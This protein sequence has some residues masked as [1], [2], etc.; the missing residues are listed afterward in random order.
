MNSKKLTE[1]FSAIARIWKDLTRCKNRI[2][3]LL[4]FSGIDIPE[5]YDNVNW[6]HNFIRK[7]SGEGERLII[8]Q[9]FSFK[10]NW[11]DLLQYYSSLAY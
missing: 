7:K 9:S 1:C 8:R 11:I 10:R 4:A 5:Q 2:K 3:G 6:S